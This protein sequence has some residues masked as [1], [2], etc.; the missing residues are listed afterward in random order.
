MRED[1]KSAVERIPAGKAAAQLRVQAAAALLGGE[2][3][4][5]EAFLAVSEQAALGALVEPGLGL[6]QGQQGIADAALQLLEKMQGAY[7][8]QCLAEIPAEERAAVLAA[9]EAYSDHLETKVRAVAAARGITV[10]A[11]RR[12]TD[13]AQAQAEK[14]KAL[15][16]ES[17]L[18]SVLLSSF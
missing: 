2:P 16:K 15:L 4:E 18:Q 5:A 3:G 6:L 14:E 1:S 12:E 11:S 9:V 8:S 10:S 17:I 7:I 13:W